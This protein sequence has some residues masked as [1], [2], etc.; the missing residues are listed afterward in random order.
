MCLFSYR[1][2]PIKNPTQIR[3]LIRSGPTSNVN[4]DNCNVGTF[5]VV[6]IIKIAVESGGEKNLHL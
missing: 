6:E 2:N 4:F 1:I 5:M 3:I